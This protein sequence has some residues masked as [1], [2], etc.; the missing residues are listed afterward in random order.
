M[1]Y[2]HIKIPAEGQAITANEDLSLNVP[3]NPVI[4]YIEGDGIGIDISPVM[5]KVVDAA[6]YR[7]HQGAAY[8]PCRRRYP[9]PERFHTP[10]PGPVRLRSSG[11]LF[12]GYRNTVEAAGRH[13]YDDFPGKYRRHICRY[14]MG[15]RQ[16]A[17]EEG[18]SVPDRGNE[19]DQH[20]FS[21]NL[22]YRR[23]AGL[24]RG[25]KAPGAQ[26]PAIRNRQRLQFASAGT[27]GQYHE[28][29]RGCFPQ[30]GL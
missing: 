5:I 10:A 22:G 9:F 24:F 21:G 12:Q 29:Y 7:L 25:H 26:G 13:Q 27:Q 19:R 15:I 8:H 11:A 20:S 6:L 2:Q 1:S 17:G 3:D 16:S 4:P 28:I 18:D 14:R 23:Q 30:L